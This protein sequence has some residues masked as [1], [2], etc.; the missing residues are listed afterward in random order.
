MMRRLLDLARTV[1]W[2]SY[3]ALACLLI[4]TWGLIFGVMVTR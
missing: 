3:G 1:D 2:Q 4:C